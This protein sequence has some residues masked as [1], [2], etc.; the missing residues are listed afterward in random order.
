MARGLP[1]VVHRSG[2]AWTDLAEEGRYG[3]GYETAEEAAEALARL[4]V[5]S[6]IWRNYSS[7][8]KFRVADLMFDGFVKKVKELL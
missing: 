5:G 6:I 2:G 1:V 3:L 4:L 7:G 8:T